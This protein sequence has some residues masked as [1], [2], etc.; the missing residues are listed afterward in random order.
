[1]SEL[2]ETSIAKK[3]MCLIMRNGIELWLDEDKA[4]SVGS[5]LLSNSKGIMKIDGRFIN[6]VDI[7]G[8]FT[9]A[10]LEEYRKIKRGMWK[11]KYNCWHEKEGICECGRAH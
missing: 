2:G 9:P 7:I 8:I 10:D 1:M 5:S 4:E 6:S 3:Q 11:C